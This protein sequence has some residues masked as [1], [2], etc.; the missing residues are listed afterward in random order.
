MEFLYGHL[1]EAPG[2]FYPP[3]MWPEYSYIAQPAPICAREW[4]GSDP[5]GIRWSLW[6]FTFED[7]TGDTAPDMHAS[8]Q[9]KLARTR[10]ITWER[11]RPGP[12]PRGWLQFTSAPSRVD[13]VVPLAEGADY[14]K[15]WHKN[16]RRDLR[17]FK[18]GLQ[19]GRYAIEPL[20]WEQ[21]E[22]SYKGSMVA[23]RVDLSRLDDVRHRLAYT[24]TRD[25]IEFWGVRD[26]ESGAVVAGTGIIYSPTH[27]SSTHIAP[28]ILEGGR[29]IYAATGLIDHWFAR[30]QERGYHYATTLNFWFKGRPKE[31][32]GFSE[33]KSHFGFAFVAYPP[34][35]Y[36]FVV[37]KIF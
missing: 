19:A 14:T 8:R 15:R 37:G 27:K 11:V 24:Q 25:N 18:E 2:D 30:T 34:I 17:L 35:L 21:F 28:F 3:E 23:K 12:V 4:V 33:F 10:A 22:T 13:G 16:A 32:K 1:E 9:G 6:P 7:Y 31:W 29:D 20:S 26:A 5:R 36:K